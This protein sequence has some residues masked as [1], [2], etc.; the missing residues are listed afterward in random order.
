MSGYAG[1][2][3]RGDPGECRGMAGS[4]ITSWAPKTLL[5]VGGIR[6][7]QINVRENHAIIQSRESVRL[8]IHVDRNLRLAAHVANITEKA[9]KTE[10]PVSSRVNT[11]GDYSA[12]R[13]C[14]R[15]YMRHRFRRR[16]NGREFTRRN[17]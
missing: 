1:E 14:P 15:C 9:N 7:K 6:I 16:Y 11:V 5:L 13:Y 3:N 12:P 4:E 10:F 2:A 8:G 17:I